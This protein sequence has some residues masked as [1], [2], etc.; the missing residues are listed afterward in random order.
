MNDLQGYYKP[1]F[2]TLY[3]RYAAHAGLSRRAL[4]EALGAASFPSALYHRDPNARAG[5]EEVLALC[6]PVMDAF[7]PAPVGGWL[8][9]IYAF[10]ADKLFP[11]ADFA[12][13]VQPAKQAIEFFLTV[14]S[15]L[16]ARE[17]A[18]CPF[19]PL[20]DI[21]Q[22][23]PQEQSESAIVSEYATFCG[24]V[25][26]SCFPALMRIGRDIMPFDPASHTIGVH[27][28]AVHMA[29]LAAKAGLP[30]DLALV[31]AA[32]LSHDIGKFG[33]RG[34][35]ARRVPYLHYYYTWD[36]LTRGGMPA[37]AHIA[38]NHSTWDLEF[39]NLQLESL[40]LIYAD[41]RVRGMRD[42]TGKERV[43]IYSLAEAYERNLRQAR[44]Y[45][46]GKKP[47]ISHGIR[48]AARF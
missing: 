13:P 47:A 40:L 11:D 31:S 42:K 27:N 38:A 12:P 30:V 5:A 46:G 2:D 24:A 1:L 29:R 45:D 48:K 35:D 14:F 7:A 39:E 4:R 6:K 43:A 28:V 25:R 41:F 37:I 36:W 3:G 8:P 34:R 10:L 23:S 32:S 15:W 22:L 21:L 17:Q 18:H 20:T 19:D 33:C 26:E 44:R 16:L 9:Y